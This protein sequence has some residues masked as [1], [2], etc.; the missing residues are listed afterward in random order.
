MRNGSMPPDAGS[1]LV[2]L[3]HRAAE[4]LAESF[5]AVS[6]DSG[7]T[8]LRDW[9]VLA[10]IDDGSARTQA[11]IAAELSIDKTTLVAILDRMERSGLVT[12]TI[13]PA[14]RRARVPHITDAGRLLKDQVTV[15]REAALD[16]RLA[17]ISAG[18][19]ESF[20]A[21]LLKIVTPQGADAPQPKTK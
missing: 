21:T 13:S 10:L 8:D 15:A 5:N 14:D 17:A 4:S 18:D 2:W 12:R 3:A 9:L 11:E 6:R 20:H 7:L 19:R 16:D 1:D